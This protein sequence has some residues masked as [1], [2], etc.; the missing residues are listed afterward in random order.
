[1]KPMEG[2]AEVVVMALVASMV[3]RVVRRMVMTGCYGTSFMF[4]EFSGLGCCCVHCGVP[5]R[6]FMCC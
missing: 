5:S 3:A 2:A 4:E 6:A 1:M